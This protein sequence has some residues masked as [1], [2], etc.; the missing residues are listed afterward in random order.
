MDTD[1]AA[2]NELIAIQKYREISLYPEV[3]LAIQD[4]V[5]EAVPQE[6]IGEQVTLNL[7]SLD[8]S[9]QLKEKITDEF[10]HVL[11]ILK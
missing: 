8:L 10:K 3:D 11:K 7:D 1:G 2:K 6:D 4:I 5:N 9:D